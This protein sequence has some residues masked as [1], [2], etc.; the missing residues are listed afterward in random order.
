M[1]RLYSCMT[2]ENLLQSAVDNDYE[3]IEINEGSLGYGHMLLLSHRDGWCN[4]EI[5]EKYLNEWSSAH[6]IRKFTKISKRI[7]KLIDDAHEIGRGVP[8]I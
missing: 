6:T 5:T 7:Q 2:V 3:I 4:V 1:A 8:T